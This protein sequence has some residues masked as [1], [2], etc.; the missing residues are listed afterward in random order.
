[1]NTASDE[2]V[3]STTSTATHISNSGTLR[4]LRLI[5]LVN[6]LVVIGIFV[7]ALPNEFIVLRD[8]Q[9]WGMGYQTALAEI[10]LS[11]D[12]FA[13]SLTGLQV[14]VAIGVTALAAFIFQKR[15]DDW[16]A[17]LVSLTFIMTI[18]TVTLPVSELNPLL[19]AIFRTA[20]LLLFV[21]LILVFPN[22]RFV[23][24]WIGWLFVPAV[25]V[26]IAL[27]P[28][29]VAVFTGDISLN[30]GSVIFLGGLIVLIMLMGV[31][32]QVYRYQHDSTPLQRQQTKWI[33]LGFAVSVA[34]I[35]VLLASQVF[36]PALKLP[37]W[38]GQEIIHSRSSLLAIL[39]LLPLLFIADA[40]VPLLT[41]SL[42]MIR[43]GLWNV[44]IVINRSLVYGSVTLLLAAIF[45]GIISLASV[46]TQGHGSAIGAVGAAIVATAL[47]NPA[48]KQ[49]QRFVDR[50]IYHLNFDLNQLAEAQKLPAIK[51]PGALSGHKLGEFTVLDVIG[52]GGMGEVYKGQAD[53]Q[54]VALK[55]LPDDLAQDK[56]FRQR[57]EREGEM[58]TGL[59]HP[60]I[61]KMIASGTSEGTAFLAMEYVEG[62]ELGRKLKSTGALS[63]D[64]T[65]D[66][67]QGLASALDYAHKQGLVHRDIKPSNVMLRRSTDGETW[68]AV[69]M[70]FGVAKIREAQTGLTGTGAIGTIDYMAPE[71]I[72]ASAQVDRRADIYALGVM[73]YEMLTGERPFKGSA[74]QIMFAHLQQPP[75]DPR[76]M[77]EAIP[78]QAAQAVMRAMAKKPEERFTTAGEFAAAL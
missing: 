13:V 9:R 35:I 11:R 62:E 60:N 66:I 65:R 8:S 32:A 27:I 18:A 70:D 31:A 33:T 21:A 56:Q 29:Q 25:P 57:F 28:L 16:M 58:L 64:E 72:M 10:G 41:V 48:R 63:L 51:N 42:S 59:H 54:T 55:I 3:A 40:F 1:M 24:R 26:C 47:F 39:F 30:S 37:L 50:H 68:E 45:A 74:A 36:F 71:Q 69:L 61:V 4:T 78:T 22:G 43:Y 14:L 34:G 49:A 53:G 75:P 44:D 12:F 2:S 23:P 76:D 6:A 15:S 52:K 5:W 19:G 38:P 67:L 73:A 77:D 20:G 46:V 17:L 7:A